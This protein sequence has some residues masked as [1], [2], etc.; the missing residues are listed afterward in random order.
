[1]MIWM[2]QVADLNLVLVVHCVKME[3]H[4][5]CEFGLQTGTLA[6]ARA[7][8]YSYYC[9]CHSHTNAKLYHSKSTLGYTGYG[10][11]EFYDEDVG[12]KQQL[13]DVLFEITNDQRT[14]SR[15][16]GRW[17]EN[18]D[19]HETERKLL[20]ERLTSS[21][22]SFVDRMNQLLAAKGE[23]KLKL[24]TDDKAEKLTWG[25]LDIKRSGNKFAIAD[26]GGSIPIG[27]TLRQ[28]KEKFALQLPERGPKE[29]PNKVL[30]KKPTKKRLRIE[31]SSDE[32][33]GGIIQKPQADQ[34]PSSKESQ[35]HNSSGIEV[36]IRK[37]AETKQA[38]PTSSVNEIKRGLG[39]SANQLEEG[40]NQLDH[41]NRAS[42]M[43]ACNDEMRE[44]VGDVGEKNI[45]SSCINAWNELQHHKSEYPSLYQEMENVSDELKAKLSQWKSNAEEMTRARSK[46]KDSDSDK[47]A[48]VS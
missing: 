20:S 19:N 34:P 48:D 16:I 25:F 11:D 6:E 43:A 44:I 10:W 38:N 13:L 31:E 8:L 39:F 1:M 45:L 46:T 28:W 24:I 7:S 32:E 23:G 12:V 9:V 4:V 18:L 17:E 40:R 5:N 26:E 36:Q 41:E 35:R 2:V 21:Y 33:D 30:N 3:S 42:A 15:A 27:M 14:G 22:K 29:A 47:L 37:S